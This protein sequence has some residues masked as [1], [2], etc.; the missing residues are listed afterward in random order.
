MPSGVGVRH[1]LRADVA[2]EIS[3]ARSSNPSRFGVFP[4]RPG[5]ASCLI[6]RGGLKWPHGTCR[7]SVSY[8]VTHGRYA[9]AFVGFQ[10]RWGKR[11]QTGWT[12]IVQWPSMKV[13]ATKTQL[14]GLAIAPTRDAP[15]DF[16]WAKQAALDAA[17]NY[18]QR[19]AGDA[20]V[21]AGARID[22]PTNH[23]IVYL[24]HAPRSILD[25]L[26]ARYPGTYVVHNNATRTLHAVM[27]VEDALD[28]TALRSKGIAI[29]SAGPTMDGHLK[30]GVEKNIAKA[31]A[32]FDA[33]YGRGFVRV[34]HGEMG[35]TFCACGPTR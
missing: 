1:S 15:S 4:A 25:A 18:A 7:T 19:V 9:E 11:G 23:T 21:F 28:F 8:P 14:H 16:S 13:A 31:Q 30:V 6:P 10:E 17:A 24:V 35:T 12:V 26:H 20:H 32:Y 27:E 5:S 29:V 22:N 34:V 2:A 33:T 3:A